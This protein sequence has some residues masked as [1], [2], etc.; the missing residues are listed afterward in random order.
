MLP[1]RSTLLLGLLALCFPA[2]PQDSGAERP[3]PR[4]LAAFRAEER[5]RLER[6]L[7][8]AW[9]LFTYT[10]DGGDVDPR[11]ARGFATFHQGYMSLILQAR[12]QVQRLL[13]LPGPEYTIQAAGFRYRV[14]EDL[15]LQTA[16]VL[17]FSNANADRELEFEST[18][19]AREYELRL[20]RD[21]LVLSRPNATFTFRRMPAGEFPASAIE[22]LD[23][24]RSGSVPPDPEQPR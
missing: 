14:S 6:E 10:T 2:A 3:A 7:E 23:R 8:G 4:S 13:R 11:D 16:S 19:A 9:S 20:V 17:G 15:A 12:E 18:N 22:S 5:Q 24:S 21:E 1:G